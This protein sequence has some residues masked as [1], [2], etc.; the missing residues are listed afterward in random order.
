MHILPK[1]GNNDFF[2]KRFRVKV[3]SGSQLKIMAV[4]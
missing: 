3:E 1:M 4:L 2:L